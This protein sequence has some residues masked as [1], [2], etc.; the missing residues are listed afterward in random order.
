MS[1]QCAGQSVVCRQASLAAGSIKE[2]LQAKSG[3]RAL[4]QRDRKAP[5]L[6]QSMWERLV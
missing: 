2:I 1:K 6:M 5:P 4:R 3:E